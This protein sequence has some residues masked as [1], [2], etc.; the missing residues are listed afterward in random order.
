MSESE[1]RGLHSVLIENPSEVENQKDLCLLI[2][3]ISKTK[4]RELLKKLVKWYHSKSIELREYPRRPFS[5][6]VEHAS[7]GV[8]F[9]YFIQNISNDGVFIQTD[10][11]FHIGQQIIMI[12]FLP[13]FEEDITV[14]GKVVRVDSQ[15]IGVKFD[16][17]IDS[18]SIDEP[19]I[20]KR[21]FL[22]KG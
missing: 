6:P 7:N 11:K 4:R 1:R 16:E 8:N 12:F 14:S 13:K 21:Q 18:K 9:I 22:I 10:G 20:S 19:S 15:G 2:S 17:L 5:I 3:S